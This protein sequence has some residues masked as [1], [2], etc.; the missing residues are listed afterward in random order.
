MKTILYARVSTAEQTAD[1]QAT[2]ARAAGFAIDEVVSDEG[3]SGVS[4]PLRERP[5]GR[6][7]FDHAGGRRAGRSMG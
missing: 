3:V 5:E 2:M 1:H 4:V 7:L 6:R